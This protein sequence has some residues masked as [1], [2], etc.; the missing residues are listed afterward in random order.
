LLLVANATDRPEEV[1]PTVG[2]VL[3]PVCARRCERYESYVVLDQDDQ[4]GLTDR[5]A[6]LAGATLMATSLCAR[7]AVP[8]PHQW[9]SPSHNHDQEVAPSFWWDRY[10]E[11]G[12]LS[13]GQAILAHRDEVLEYEQSLGPSPWNQVATDYQ[14]AREVSDMV[15]FKWTIRDSYYS[16]YES[17]PNLEPVCGEPIRSD[18]EERRRPEAWVFP[19]SS[20]IRGIADRVK[21]ALAAPD[22]APDALHTLHVRRGEPADGTAGH[23]RTDVPDVVEHMQNCDPGWKN[24]SNTDVLVFFTDE[25]DQRYI[26]ELINALEAMPR[27]SAVRWGDRAIAE[28]LGSEQGG[29][30]NYFVYSVAARIMATSKHHWR[31]HRCEGRAPC[32]SSET[33]G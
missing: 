4:D 24:K 23:C 2:D 19:P 22:A 28:Q 9:L 32:S 29:D 17:L 1:V 30:D 25:T 13:D 16:W 10:I 5:I 26:E 8:P 33:P 12:Q 6:I 18:V 11:I 31:M 20:N 7:V 14:L 21:V 15:P 27:W 3:R